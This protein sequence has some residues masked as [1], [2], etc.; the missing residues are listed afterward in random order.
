MMAMRERLLDNAVWSSFLSHHRHLGRDAWSCG[1]VSHR[2]LALVAA[3]IIGL[4][5]FLHVA[6]SNEKARRVYEALGFRLRRL[7][8]FILSPRRRREGHEPPRVGTAEDSTTHEGGTGVQVKRELRGLSTWGPFIFENVDS[9]I[10][11]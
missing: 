2:R 1:P 6:E 5:P 3:G 7:V 8:E 9:I 10:E 11:R 4:Q